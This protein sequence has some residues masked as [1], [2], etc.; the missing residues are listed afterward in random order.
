[1]KIRKRRTI[2]M[3]EDIVEITKGAEYLATA[4]ALSD[5]IKALPLSYEDNQKLIDSIL[6]HSEAGRREAYSQGIIDALTTDLSERVEKYLEGS[7][8][9]QIY[10]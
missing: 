4:Q 7:N 2:T 5:V 9:G 3:Y 8:S 6:A 10:S 1:M